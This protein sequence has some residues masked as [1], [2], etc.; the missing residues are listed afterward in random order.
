MPDRGCLPVAAVVAYIWMGGYPFSITERT[1]RSFAVEITTSGIP[2]CRSFQCLASSSEQNSDRTSVTPLLVKYLLVAV[3][4]FAPTSSSVKIGDRS[5]FS[6]LTSSI[7]N[8]VAENRFLAKLKKYKIAVPTEPVP[9]VHSVPSDS[10]GRNGA[11]CG[12]TGQQ[13][14]SRALRQTALGYSVSADRK[15]VTAARIAANAGPVGL[16][17]SSSTKG[18]GGGPT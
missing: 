2:C 8:K 5:R 16:V 15:A 12:A 17:V 10:P 1:L 14:Q 9:T 7:S 6:I 18:E 4:F 13:L 11:M 3:T